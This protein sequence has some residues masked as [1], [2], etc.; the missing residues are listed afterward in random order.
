VDASDLHVLRARE[1]TREPSGDVVISRLCEADVDVAVLRV[2]RDGD[3][4]R[5]A[6][7]VHVGA[8]RAVEA[9]HD[10]LRAPGDVITGHRRP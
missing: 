7:D 3:R 10:G 2:F 9:D 1:W 8:V 4:T 6:I 5:G